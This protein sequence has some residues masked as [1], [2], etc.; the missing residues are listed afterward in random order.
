[1]FPPTEETSGALSCLETALTSCGKDNNLFVFCNDLEHRSL[2]WFEINVF[3]RDADGFEIFSGWLIGL[4]MQIV[5]SD[6]VHMEGQPSNN[7]TKMFQLEDLL[8]N[9]KSNMRTLEPRHF[10]LPHQPLLS[11]GAMLILLAMSILLYLPLRRRLPTWFD[12]YKWPIL[13]NAG[14]SF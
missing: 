1:M 10:D 9:S 7:Q 13:G 12:C 3:F 5:D 11:N 8:E 14:F 2:F 4:V 6:L